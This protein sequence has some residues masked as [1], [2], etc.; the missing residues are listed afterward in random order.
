MVPHGRTNSAVSFVQRII[1]VHL[2]KWH[3][4]VFIFL[5][6][7]TQAS[8]LM[9]LMDEYIQP[10]EYISSIRIL[11]NPTFRMLSSERRNGRD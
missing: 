3:V 10:R 8:A 11:S 7:G 2:Q 5:E 1:L 9:G 4:A 6:R